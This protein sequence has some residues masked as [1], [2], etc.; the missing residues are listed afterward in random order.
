MN[1]EKLTEMEIEA[2]KHAVFNMAKEDGIKAC[3]QYRESLK[4]NEGFKTELR[5]ETGDLWSV[6]II[7]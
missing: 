5:Y 7:L 2:M 4:S 6:H 1:N 3:R